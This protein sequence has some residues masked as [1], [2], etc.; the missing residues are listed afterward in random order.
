MNF[1]RWRCPP[2]KHVW[3][4]FDFIRTFECRYIVRTDGTIF[5]IDNLIKMHRESNNWNDLY[6][7]LWQL[8]LIAHLWHI[9]SLYLTSNKCQQ[10]NGYQEIRTLARKIY[11]YQGSVKKKSW[12]T[13]SV[14]VIMGRHHVT[15]VLQRGIRHTVMPRRYTYSYHCILIRSVMWGTWGSPFWKLYYMNHVLKH[16]TLSQKGRTRQKSAAIQY[17]QMKQFKITLEY[18]FHQHE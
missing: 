17:E 13:S 5:W 3:K 10:D 14:T 8:T 9:R 4:Q 18:P 6:K 16:N 2:P 1:N 7:S 12:V 11:F 15:E